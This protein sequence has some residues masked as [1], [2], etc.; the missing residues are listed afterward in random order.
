ML[1]RW[2]R[3]G[4]FWK[5]LYNTFPPLL[6]FFSNALKQISLFSLPFYLVT[7]STTPKK[8]CRRRLLMP[9]W[10]YPEKV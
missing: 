10:E 1:T 6:H 4:Y 3:A 2:W 9:V 5:C 8:A 7:P